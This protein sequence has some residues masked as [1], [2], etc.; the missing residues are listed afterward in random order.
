MT[1]YRPQVYCAGTLHR[2]QLFR[3]LRDDPEW[4]FCDFTSSWINDHV[5]PNYE[6]SAAENA[7]GWSKNFKE[8]KESDFVLLYG[9]EDVAKLR[10]ALVE[11][12]YGLAERCRVV[13]VGLSGDHTWS[14]H[15]HV[16]R[17]N[18]LIMAR[19]HLLRYT[20]M[21]GKRRKDYD[22]ESA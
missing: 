10:G 22:A 8:I 16:T 7:V 17:C 5:D 12:G 18:N 3:T 20:V 4:Q 11:C 14:F 6:Y 9:R 15:P 13:T 2:G 1:V 21:V 19:T